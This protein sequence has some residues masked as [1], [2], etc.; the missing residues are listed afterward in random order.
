[1][2]AFDAKPS[3]DG[4]LVGIRRKA[5]SER[6]RHSTPERPIDWGE[7]EHLAF[8]RRLMANEMISFD[9]AWNEINRAAREKY[10][11][12][13][14]PTVEALMYSLRECGVKALEEPATRRRLSNLSDQQVIEVGNRLQKL[15]PE[16]ACAWSA[17]EVEALFKLRGLQ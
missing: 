6:P 8:L 13:P 12:A 14:Q 2:S 3:T 10:N 11:G 15:K 17:E 9:A 16:I 7:S 5:S 4:S 1:M